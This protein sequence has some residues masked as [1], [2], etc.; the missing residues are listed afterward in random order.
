[1]GL[2]LTGV[3][4]VFV[5][6]YYFTPKYTR[7]GYQPQQPVPFSH[8]LHIGQ[9][10][11]DC[12]YC[13][14]HVDEAP[15]A[16]VPATQTCMNCHSKVKGTSPLLSQIRESYASG[17]PVHWVKI[18]ELPQYA[19]FNHAIHVNRGVG[20]V[21]CHGQVNEM[22]VVYHD[23]PLAMS[24]CL[25]C[26]RNP[27]QHLRPADEVTNLLWT[28]P[29]GKSALEVGMD[30]KTFLGVEPPQSCNGCHR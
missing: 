8:A 2:G 15:L 1:M 28:P 13:H 27:E 9:L 16:N 11:L 29:E 10:G 4:V 19:Y 12:R 26:H 6:S 30:L 18:H 24:W 14:T 22:T 20:C 5:I 23:Q 25:D 21:S 7:V 17:T 3:L